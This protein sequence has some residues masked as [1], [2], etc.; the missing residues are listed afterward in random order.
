MPRGPTARRTLS[1]RLSAGGGGFTTQSDGSI[2]REWGRAGAA[3]P[4]GRLQLRCDA[5]LCVA[6]DT[7]NHYATVFFHHRGLKC[8]VEQHG[9]PAFVPAAPRRSEERP[10][11][12]GARVLDPGTDLFGAPAPAAEAGAAATRAAAEATAAAASDD[13]RSRRDSGPATS[14]ADLLARIRESTASL[15]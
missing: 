9:A 15:Q 4:P 12:G 11:A 10:L 3:A 13:D 8:A 7:A 6:V 14:H 1:P 5:A 2:D